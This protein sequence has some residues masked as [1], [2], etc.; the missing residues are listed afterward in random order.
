V[1]ARFLFCG[2]KDRLWPE[3]KTLSAFPLMQMMM[4]ICYAII[5]FIGAAISVVPNAV[6]RADWVWF[7]CESMAAQADDQGNLALQLL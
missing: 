5:R 3:S 6:A 2:Y 4:P 1:T 7:D